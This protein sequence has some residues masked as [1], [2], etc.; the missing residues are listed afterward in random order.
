MELKDLHY[1]LRVVQSKS[2]VN[3]DQL[4]EGIKLGLDKKEILSKKAFDRVSKQFK[5]DDYIA[6]LERIFIDNLNK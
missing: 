4:I 1:Q 3:V 6:K 5:F 2:P